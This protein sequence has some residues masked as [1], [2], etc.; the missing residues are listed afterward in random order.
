MN[1]GRLFEAKR[2]SARNSDI[3]IRKPAGKGLGRPLRPPIVR[4]AGLR[5]YSTVNV[6][7]NGDLQPL[8]KS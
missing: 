7:K 5:P 1:A 3:W 6:K 4:L 8:D 2:R